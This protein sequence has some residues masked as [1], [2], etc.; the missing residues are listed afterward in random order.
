MAL[1]AAPLTASTQF[2]WY[3][4]G[5]G[6]WFSAF[7]IQM[8]MFAYLVTTV[9]HAPPGLIGL[10]QASPTLVATFLLLVGG[11]VADQTDTR[12]LLILAHVIAIVPAIALAA[13]VAAGLLR[14]EWLIVYG[15]AM[16]FVTAFIIPAREAMMADVIGPSAGPQIQQAVTTTVGVTFLAQIAGMFTARLAATLGAAPIILVQ[17]VLQVLG[18]FTSYKLN[19]STRH[20]VHAEANGGSQLRR[21]VAGLREVAGSPVL[22][23]IT[24]ITAAIGVLFIG[25]FMVI[26]PVILR[27][28]YG[29]DVMQF[30]SMQVAFWS[31]SIL[32]SM[33]ISRLGNITNRGRPVVFAVSTGTTVLILMSFKAPLLVFYGLVFLWG[34]GAGVTIS[35]ARTIVQEYAPPAHRARVLSIYQLGFTGGMAVGSLATGFIVSM[36]GARQAALVPALAM[37]VVVA[38][39]LTRTKL[40]SITALE[41]ETGP[42]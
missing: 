29:G 13:V 35:M 5:A 34:I 4:A 22:M 37:M 23:P 40:W 9:L 26:L 15:L 38:Y 41:H 33:T 18:A 6:A 14:F 2:R 32:S 36:L 12:R 3:L 21:I 19:P 39:L 10:A 30:S 1:P 17:A 31:G 27:D 20:H 42:A 28:E 24:V 11:A 8:V 16:G 7:G 25:A